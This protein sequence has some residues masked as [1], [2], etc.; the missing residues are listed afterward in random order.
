MKTE[1]LAKLKTQVEEMQ[2][3]L[4][5]L[6]DE[7]MQRLLGPGLWSGKEILGHLAD[8]QNGGKFRHMQKLPGVIW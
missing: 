8:R 2:A 3:A 4:L 7:E 6:S 1:N 5:Q